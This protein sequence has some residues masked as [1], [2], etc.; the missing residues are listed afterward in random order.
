MESLFPGLEDHLIKWNHIL[1]VNW[2]IFAWLFV[3]VILV[4]QMQYTLL[5]HVKSIALMASREE[6]TMQ[7]A[8]LIS[9]LISCSQVLV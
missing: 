1:N 3:Q 5:V 9:L 6:H 8:S 7:T 4:G 2:T